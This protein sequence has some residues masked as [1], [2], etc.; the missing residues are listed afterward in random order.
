MKLIHT[1]SGSTYQYD[2]DTQTAMRIGRG[3][4]FHDLA[5]DH[6]PLDLLLRV[7]PKV[8]EQMFLDG[9][10]GYSVVTTPVVSVENV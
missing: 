6:E 9:K 2:E 3:E 7:H 8:G 1:H 5:V 10:N 4:R